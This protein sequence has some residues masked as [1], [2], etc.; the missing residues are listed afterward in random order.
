MRFFLRRTPRFAIRAFWTKKIQRAGC[1]F[2]PRLRRTFGFRLRPT[3]SD[4]TYS[5]PVLAARGKL[6]PRSG[7]SRPLRAPRPQIAAFSLHNGMFA[8]RSKRSSGGFRRWSPAGATTEVGRGE[9]KIYAA[10]PRLTRDAGTRNFT[11]RAKKGAG[12]RHWRAGTWSSPGGG[13]GIGKAIAERLAAEGASL[14][15]LAP[16]LDELEEVAAASRRRRA[17]LRHPRPRPASTRRSPPPPR[18]AVRSTRSS[19]TAASAARTPTAP[20]TASRRSS[21]TNLFGT[22]LVRPRGRQA[23]RGRAGDA[24]RRRDRVDPRPDRGARATRP[25]APRRRGCSGSCA[26]SPPSSR[27]PTCR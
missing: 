13:R 15:L 12:W 10:P 23:A 19:P 17:V 14:S 16:N 27:R 11:Q 18:R 9:P 1:A 25:T 26:R 3:G 4:S 22:L 21:Q 2:V 20:T 24:S 7:A 5:R 6:R 8:H